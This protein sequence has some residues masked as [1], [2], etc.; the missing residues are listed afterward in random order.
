MM[1]CSSQYNIPGFL[2]LIPWLVWCL[3]NLHLVKLLFSF[4]MSVQNESVDLRKQWNILSQSED[5]NP[6]TAFQKTRRT[7]LCSCKVRAHFWD[8]RLYIKWSVSESLHNPDL[9]AIVAPHK[10]KNN[11]IFQGVVLL[12]LGE[13]CSLWL[14]R[15]FCWWGRFDQCIMQTHSVQYREERRPKG[16]ENFSLYFSCLVIKWGFYFVIVSVVVVVVVFNEA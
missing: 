6:G 13:C 5:Y 14:S 7:I 1:L 4:V 8:R 11:G 16:I 10:M 9:S 3:P 12:V 15:Y 2:T